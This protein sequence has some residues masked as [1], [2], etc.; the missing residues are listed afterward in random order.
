LIVAA[1]VLGIVLVIV[2]FI[3]G[4]VALLVAGALI[5]L[6][7]VAFALWGIV[8]GIV[9]RIRSAPTWWQG[10]IGFFVGI[11]DIVGIPGVIEGLI[12]RDLVTWKKLSVEEAGERFGSG[13]FGL[14][15][16][17]IPFL[18]AKGVRGRGGMKPPE[19]K[20]PEIKPP[21]PAAPAPPPEPP[22]RSP[23]L[24]R[25]RC[26]DLG[27]T[28]TLASTQSSRHAG[29]IFVVQ[30]RASR[31]RAIT[32]PPHTGHTCAAGADRC[33]SGVSGA[34]PIRSP[35]APRALSAR[36]MSRAGDRTVDPSRF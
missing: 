28:S 29:K 22:D 12:G 27:G 21:E 35:T 23:R 6:G 2:G 33:A 5:L 17:I 15:T 24:S 32:G 4:S 14:L 34:A 9:N 30:W 11:L 13:L 20:P 8:S 18:K 3:S 1:A 10:L 7:V 19:I 31:R 36:G 25:G 26:R 16:A